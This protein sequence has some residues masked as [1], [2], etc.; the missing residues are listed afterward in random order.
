MSLALPEIVY[1]A[2]TRS[3]DYYLACSFDSDPHFGHA[4][5]F[6]PQHP[7]RMG[8]PFVTSDTTFSATA[9]ELNISHE[10]ALILDDMRFLIMAIL[11]YISTLPSDSEQAK[12]EATALWISNRISALPDGSAPDSPLARDHI[13]KSVLI[14][15]LILCRS[16]SS[17]QPLNKCCSLSDLRQ[18]WA[19]MW[20][21]T[22][23]R[24]KQIPGIFLFIV[25]AAIPAAQETPHGRFLKSMLKTTT[26][27]ISLEYW[28]V[29][30]CTLMSYVELQRWL[31]GGSAGGTAV[32]RA[33]KPL[34][35]VHIYRQ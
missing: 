25:L 11:S 5:D 32:V 24:W 15:A 9:D 2:E 29:V 12:F 8:T 20:R 30:D 13:Y 27:Y 23:S 7:A 28:E 19:N 10:T 4:I 26:A 34:D 14:A 18:L 16:I 3:N 6:M 22:L 21:V 33:A 17:R 31:R 35:F 1:L